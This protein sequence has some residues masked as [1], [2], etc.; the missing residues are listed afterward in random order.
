MQNSQNRRSCE[1]ENRIY[2]TY[3]YTGITH[4]RHIYAKEYDMANAIMCAYQQSDHVLPH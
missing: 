2:E 1:K 4:R 3:K